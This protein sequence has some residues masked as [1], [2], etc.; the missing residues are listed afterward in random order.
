METKGK[1]IVG[2]AD[3]VTECVEVPPS[4]NSPEVFIPDDMIINTQESKVENEIEAKGQES[5]DLKY[6]DKAEKDGK[7]IMEPSGPK[8]EQ[9]TRNNVLI[10]GAEAQQQE[11][12]RSSRLRGE[13]TKTT[14]EKNE[15][16]SRK[17]FRR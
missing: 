10:P 16:M 17:G 5:E 6:T 9:S 4:S 11:K 1:E 13:I 15:A 8:E 3:M 7:Q 12:R 14:L 2:E